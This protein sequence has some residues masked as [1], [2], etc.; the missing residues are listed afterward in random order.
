MVNQLLAFAGQNQAAPRA[1]D[2]SALVTEIARYAR[3]IP[4]ARAAIGEE[5]A[6]DLP[7][8]VADPMQ[9][10]QVVLNLVVNA[11]DATRESG[12]RVTV[13]TR[14]AAGI[15]P[16]EG[17]VLQGQPASRYLVIEVED[18]G[19]G[20]DEPARHRIFDPFFTTKPNGH[21]LGLATVIGAVRAHKG[22]LA[23][24]SEP[25]QGARFTVYLPLPD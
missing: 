25:G 14:L 19:P 22:T 18:D 10:R 1:V 20:I 2:V 12:S 8:I 7:P 16:G 3:R 13:R 4:G 9:L 11:L 5:L 23:V 15:E 6:S 21:G 24:R 17:P